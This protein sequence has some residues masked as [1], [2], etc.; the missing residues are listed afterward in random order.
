MWRLVP[1]AVLQTSRVCV[2]TH[3]PQATSAM[4]MRRGGAFHT[5]C[6]LRTSERDNFYAHPIEGLNPVVDIS[7][8]EV[9]RIDEHC[10]VPVPQREY[11]YEAAA[12]PHLRDDLNAINVTQPDGV[13][14]SL[15]GSLLKWARMVR[16]DRLQRTRGSDTPRS[17]LQRSSGVVSRVAGR[18][19]GTV[20][21]KPDTFVRTSLIL[22]NMASAS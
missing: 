10:E 19:G 2:S 18:N 13:S 15:E 21:Q 4:K 22:A 11:N 17:A 16:Q 12:Q 1:G 7:T 3:G 20:V 6:W 14:F 8:M 5:F 9:I